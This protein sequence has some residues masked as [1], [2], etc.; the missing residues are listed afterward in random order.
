MKFSSRLS[1]IGVAQYSADAA[2][3]RYENQPGHA[4]AAQ[5]RY[6]FS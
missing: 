3:W 6:T 2:M 4:K 5:V 1:G